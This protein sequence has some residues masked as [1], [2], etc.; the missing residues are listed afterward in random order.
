[1]GGKSL[2]RRLKITAGLTGVYAG[3]NPLG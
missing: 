3:V 2:A 1:M